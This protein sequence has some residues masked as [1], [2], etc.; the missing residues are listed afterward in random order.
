MSSS[1]ASA[2]VRLLCSLRDLTVLGSRPRFSPTQKAAPSVCPGFSFEKWGESDLR[3]AFL[4][5]G[6]GVVSKSSAAGRLNRTV[7]GELVRRERGS[8]TSGQA[9][10]KYLGMLSLRSSVCGGKRDYYA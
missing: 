4:L 10:S 2:P 6:L 1:T 5:P 7:G 9:V 3:V 8:Q